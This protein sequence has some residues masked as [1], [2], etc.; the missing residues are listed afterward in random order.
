[1]ELTLTTDERELLM[2]IL[3]ER[4]REL[5]REI[6]RSN[7]HQFRTALKKNERLLETLIGKLRAMQMGD[8]P[9]VPV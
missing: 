7:H 6:S 5:L 9:A 3:E 8:A 2:E 1:M 4:Q